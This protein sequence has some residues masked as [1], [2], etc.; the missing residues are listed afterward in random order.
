MV[1][2]YEVEVTLNVLISVL[3]QGR[4]G[5]LARLSMERRQVLV[6]RILWVVILF[7]VVRES[8]VLFCHGNGG[9]EG[10]HA[11]NLTRK[12]IEGEED[13]YCSGA[14]GEW[15]ERLLLDRW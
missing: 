10:R 4:S 13:V 3:K 15:R 11:T 5:A 9:V 2:E 6:E 7:Q 12:E 14:Y 8:T 1:E